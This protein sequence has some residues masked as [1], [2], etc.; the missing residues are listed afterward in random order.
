MHLPGVGAGKSKAVEMA[1]GSG[2]ELA[3]ATQERWAMVN[4]IGKVLAK[5]V[6]EAVRERSKLL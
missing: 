5:R 3:E 1:F 2:L 6:W 4:G